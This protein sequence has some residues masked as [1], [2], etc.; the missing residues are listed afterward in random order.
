[1]TK[2]TLDEMRELARRWESGETLAA[3]GKSL[4][5]SGQRVRQLISRAR[6]ADLREWMLANGWTVGKGGLWIYPPPPYP[7]YDRPTR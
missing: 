5:M 6:H 7:K 4:G 3:I 1:M 2:R